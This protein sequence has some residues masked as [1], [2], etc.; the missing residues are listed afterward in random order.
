MN[1]FVIVCSTGVQIGEFF[2]IFGGTLSGTNGGTHHLV[3][4][5][6][7]YHILKKTWVKGNLL[8]ILFT[9]IFLVMFITGPDLPENIFFM[10]APSVSLNSSHAVI[11]GANVD[12]FGLLIEDDDDKFKENYFL[13]LV[14]D[15]HL[16]IWIKWAKLPIAQPEI[17]L[18][19]LYHYPIKSISAVVFDD[20]YCNRYVTYF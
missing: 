11:F 15:F 14:Y 6:V 20:K 19:L 4:E 12:Y 18:G 17:Y 16:N 5:S 1:I 2:W 13:T 7:L 9:T 3:K 8:L 10:D